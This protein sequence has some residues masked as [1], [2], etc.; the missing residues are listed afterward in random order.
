MNLSSHAIAS[1]CAA[2]RD[3]PARIIAFFTILGTGDR[4]H[5]M[6]FACERELDEFKARNTD[7]EEWEIFYE[8][9]RYTAPVVREID[10]A[11]VRLQELFSAYMQ[12]PSWAERMA[13]Y[14]AWAAAVDDIYGKSIKKNF[15]H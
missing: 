6:E 13:A 10:P 9:A 15:R 8:T 3:Y 12:A 1:R 4:T 14:K 11:R 7:L 2:D 5:A